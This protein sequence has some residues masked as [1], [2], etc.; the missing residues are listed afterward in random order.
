MTRQVEALV[1]GTCFA[2]TNTSRVKQALS[3]G[4]VGKDVVSRIWRKVKDCSSAGG[5]NAAVSDRRRRGLLAHASE[6]LHDEVSAGYTDMI[7]AAPAK[8]LKRA[9]ALLGPLDYAILHHQLADLGVQ[10]LH[11]SFRD[12]FLRFRLG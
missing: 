4:V 11:L 3:K 8:R 1:A 10:L 7:Y 9:V 2:G 12:D 5:A 6:A